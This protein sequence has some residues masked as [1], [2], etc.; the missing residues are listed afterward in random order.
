M[1]T[2]QARRFHTLTA[3]ATS[4]IAIMF[5]TTASHRPLPAISYA[6]SLKMRCGSASNYI[7]LCVGCIYGCVWRLPGGCRREGDDDY[8]AL[9][10]TWVLA[11][12]DVT[13]RAGVVS[14]GGTSTGVADCMWVDMAHRTTGPLP[15]PRWGHCAAMVSVVECDTVVVVTVPLALFAWCR[16]SSRCSTVS[17]CSC[18]VPVLQVGNSLIVHG[19]RRG[20]EDTTELAVLTL[21]G[22]TCFVPSLTVRALPLTSLWATSLLLPATVCVTSRVDS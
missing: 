7:F 17:H 1:S 13:A 19:G 11:G 18:A 14:P 3:H 4:S 9:N 16:L 21:H 20:S 5:G 8:S 12:L 2:P 10:D 15:T 22:K 6:D